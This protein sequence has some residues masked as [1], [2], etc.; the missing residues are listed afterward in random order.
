MPFRGFICCVTGMQVSPNACYGCALKGAQLGCHFTAPIIRGITENSQDRGLNHLSV[1]ELLGCPRKVVLKKEHDYW[2]KPDEAYWA[3]RG[4]L[5]HLAMERCAQGPGMVAEKRIEAV[6]DGF[7]ITGKPDVIYPDRQSLQDYK[8]TRKVPGNWKTYTCAECGTVIR[9][10]QWAVRRGQ[11][12]T[13]QA[14]GHEYASKE[15]KDL[16]VEDPPRPYDSH[17][18]QVNLYRLILEQNGIRIDTAEIVYMDMSTVLRIP[19]EIWPLETTETL[20]I[21]RIRALQASWIPGGVQD[22]EDENWQCRFCPV[23]EVCATLDA[24]LE[25]AVGADVATEELFGF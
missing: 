11:G 25:R 1:T 9:E 3:F 5:G 2:V 14:C 4:E 13:C 17:I 20:A 24:P 6:V 10:G 22:D 12:L 19:V 16:L 15:V 18:A 21:K 8:T 7:T 23:S